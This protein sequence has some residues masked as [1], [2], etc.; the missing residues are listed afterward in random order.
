MA[1]K[2]LPI[3]AHNTDRE[4]AVTIGHYPIEQ[5]PKWPHKGPPRKAHN[6]DR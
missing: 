3:K 4:W 2:A 1:N 6:T 5:H